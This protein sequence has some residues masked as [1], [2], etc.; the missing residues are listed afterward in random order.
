MNKKTRSDSTTWNFNAAA[1]FICKVGREGFVV[2]L[3][4]TFTLSFCFHSLL[5]STSSLE[6]TKQ[7]ENEK[8]FW[9]HFDPITDRKVRFI[10][11]C[12]LDRCHVYQCDE[13]DWIY[14]ATYALRC[15]LCCSTQHYLL[16]KCIDVLLLYYSA[17][18]ASLMHCITRRRS[19]GEAE[20]RSKIQFEGN[21]KMILQQLQQRNFSYPQGDEEENF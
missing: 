4:Q 17:C 13:L 11:L 15:S 16:L 3:N 21:N 6:F 14:R 1:D 10:E 19:K 18:E 7:P 20:V 5:F 12:S 9:A 8:T 2:C